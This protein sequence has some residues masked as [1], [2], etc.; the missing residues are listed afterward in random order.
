MMAR[1]LSVLIL[2]GAVFCIAADN[3]ERRPCAAWEIGAIGLS[4]AARAIE[5]Y[6][7]AAYIPSNGM[8]RVGYYYELDGTNDILNLQQS[9]LATCHTG[10]NWSIEF[11]AARNVAPGA[12]Q[13]RYLLGN[14]I[15]SGD[16]G[17]LF[18]IYDTTAS[19]LF[20]LMPAKISY[21][22]PG[23]LTATPQ[24]FVITMSAAGV[25]R[26]Y[27]SGS[28]IQSAT[29]SGG[30]PTG[31]AT[32]NCTLGAINNNSFASA[33]VLVI[34]FYDFELSAADVRELSTEYP[35]DVLETP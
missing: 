27:R 20:Y 4:T 15:S 2:I 8:R 32:Y 33:R 35:A 29:V 21:I 23:S 24:H 10:G 7:G 9:P 5:T 13:E 14:A 22:S 31:P 16:T 25:A 3:N 11:W 30:F 26:A 12:G 17:F 6:S 18:D 1:R 19:V 34:R 28:F